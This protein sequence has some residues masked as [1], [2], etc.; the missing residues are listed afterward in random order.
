MKYQPA[1]RQLESVVEYCIE[2]GTGFEGVVCCC[3]CCCCRRRR[4]RCCRLSSQTFLCWFF[5]CWIKGDLHRSGF[6]FQTAVLTALYM[7]FLVQLSVLVDLL[8]F[9]LVWIPNF[10]LNLCY[11]S[12]GSSYYR[13]NHTLHVPTF[14]IFLYINYCIWFAFCFPSRDITVCWYCHVYQCACFLLFCF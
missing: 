1:G 2:R 9:F 7:M 3:C 11:Y 8:S 10:S 6:K 4:R 14:V 12:S 13:Y 5:S